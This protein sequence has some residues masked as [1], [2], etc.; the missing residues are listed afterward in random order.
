MNGNFFCNMIV[1][2]IPN[3]VT[4][5]NLIAGFF[6]IILIAGGDIYWGSLLILFAAFFDFIDG[7][8]AKLLHARSELG[9]QLDSLADL[10]SFG[11]APG[12]LIYGIYSVSFNYSEDYRFLALFSVLIPVFSAIRLARF[13]IDS[14]QSENFL[15]LAV[16]ANAIMIASFPLVFLQEN[17][18]FSWL[19]HTFYNTIFLTVYIVIASFLMVSSIP[20]FSLKFSG[21]GLKQ[22]LLRFVFLLCSVALIILLRF[23]ALPFIILA[24]IMISLFMLFFPDKKNPD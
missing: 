11:V 20:M 9:K 6:S 21:A 5:F 18:D 24:Y 19:S 14:K 4:L 13:N 7:A 8:F 17:P 12:F 1:K 2:N 23:K 10:V 15:G 22:N 3:L 16:P